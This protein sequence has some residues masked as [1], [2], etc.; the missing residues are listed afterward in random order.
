MGR[1]CNTSGEKRIFGGK[2]RRKNPLERRRLR[3]EDNIKNFFGEK[4]WGGVVWTG[5]IWLRIGHS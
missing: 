5:L 4:G 3:S 1:A 2:A